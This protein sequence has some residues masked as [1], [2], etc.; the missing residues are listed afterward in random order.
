[1]QLLKNVV[2]RIS[3]AGSV[4]SF[5]VVVESKGPLRMTKQMTNHHALVQA[6]MLTTHTET[7]VVM[8]THIH[9]NGWNLQ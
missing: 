9:Q 4:T 6:G 8:A 3:A 1:M 2:L 5:I 7:A